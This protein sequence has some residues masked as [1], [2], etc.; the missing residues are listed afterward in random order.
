MQYR[1]PIFDDER[2]ANEEEE[3][4]RAQAR[5]RKRLENREKFPQITAFFDEMEAQFPGC[6]VIWA[7]ENGNVV[8][9]PPPEVL[10]QHQR[11][12]AEKRQANRTD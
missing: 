4:L 9:K 8:G 12:I 11:E 3:R 6:R 1:K 7:V 2:E 10:E 5:E